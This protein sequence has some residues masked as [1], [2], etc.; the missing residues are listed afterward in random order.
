M[1]IK[2]FQDIFTEAV[3][4]VLYPLLGVLFAP[5]VSNTNQ[6]K[7]TNYP[8]VLVERWLNTHATRKRWQQY[9]QEKG[10]VVYLVN[11]KIQDGSFEESAT[12]LHDFLEREQIKDAVLVGIS[13]GGLTVLLYLQ[14][15]GWEKVKH[16]IS[17]ASPFK[18]TWIALFASYLKGVREMLPSSKLIT[19][20]SSIEIPHPERITCILANADEM[21]PSWSSS[22]DGADKIII[23]TYGHNNLHINCQE[24][25]TVIMSKGQYE[26]A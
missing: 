12:A 22:L 25:Y 20:L 5:K 13:A 16:F 3:T 26:N 8:I 2:F 19:S 18:G 23:N 10:Y 7:S 17:I 21:V 1:S 24:T 9:M 14:K 6:P 15:Y 4:F 11:F